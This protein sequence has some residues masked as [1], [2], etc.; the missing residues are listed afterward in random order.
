MSTVALHHASPEGGV[1][2]ATAYDSIAYPST[3]F[4]QTAPDRLALVARLAGL[5]PPPIATA[6][7]LEIACGDGLN[8]IALASAW[9]E[10]E[11]VGFDLAPSAI[12]RGKAWIAQTGLTNVRLEVLDI[13]DAA[14]VLEGQFDYI[15]AHGLYAW[16]PPDVRAAAMALIGDRLSADGV[17]YVSYNALPGGYFRM[18]IRDALLFAIAD[19]DDPHARIAAARANLEALVIQR[20]GESPSEAAMRAA[21]EVTLGQAD[22]VL[23]HDELGEHYHPQSLSDVISAAAAH[24]LR[25]L[26]EANVGSLHEAFVPDAIVPDPEDVETQ[27]LHI[28][29][30]EDYRFCRFFRA[31][32]LVRDAVRPARRLHRPA[33]DTLHVT[34][35]ARPTGPGAFETARTSFEITDPGLSALL[36]RMAEAAPARLACGALDLSDEHRLALFELADAGLVDLH[37]TPSPFALVVPDHPEVPAIARLLM[38]NGAETIPTLEQQLLKLPDAGVRRLLTHCDGTRDLDALAA[39]AFDMGVE[40]RATFDA[41]MASA[42]AKAVIRP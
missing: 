15:V 41:L 6:R 14:R 22:S 17:G 4:G 35:R 10:A 8:L 9:P 3:V 25:Y 1:E 28:R 32:L 18:A 27:V 5:S 16:V 34:T 26:G 7:M 12:A 2:G 42:V 30:A 13:A 39:I 37:T 11:F 36:V 20:E 31:T 24:G 38:D 19:I 40:D 33:I 23:S 21:A 29:Q